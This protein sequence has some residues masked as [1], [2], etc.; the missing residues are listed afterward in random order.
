MKHIIF[1]LSDQQR[2]DTLGCYGQ[3]LDITPNLDRLAKQGTMFEYAF[4]PQ[5]VCGPTRAVLQSG[6]FA[7]RTS[8]YRNAIALPVEEANLSR[9]LKEAGYYTGYIGKW[10][11]A[12]N[13][14]KSDIDIGP[15]F[16]YATKPIPRHL[17]GGYDFFL[18]ADVLEYTSKGRGGGHIYDQDGKTISW[19]TEYRS[20][21]MNKQ[22][23][24]FIESHKDD[25]Q[26][27]FLFVSQI[28]PHHQNNENRFEGPEGSYDK[29]KERFVIPD[30][31]RSFE[32]D[33]IE[34]YPDYLGAIERLD[35]N[36]G[37]LIHTLEQHNLLED[38]LFIYTSDH[39]SHFRTRNNEY[40]RSCHDGSIRIP[41][42][43]HGPGFMGGN[44]IQELVSL[45]DIPATI[46]A[47]ANAT[48]PNDFD[49]APIQET[50]SN[51]TSWKQDIFV[52][53]SED[54]L[55][56]A[57]RTKRFKYSVK[58][59]GYEPWKG[60]CHA[61]S[62]DVYVD[63]YL[64]DLERDPNEHDNRIEDPAYIT[65]KEDLKKQLIKRMVDAGEQAPRILDSMKKTD[66]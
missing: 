30:D 2:F 8:C 53:I 59:P 57:I 37:E 48:I 5:P 29:F 61:M 33:Y 49:G 44:K 38:T 25:D 24:K 13:T 17:Q 40:K 58:A 22:A 26:P 1:Y 16:D 10:H 19:D 31:L 42:V 52:Q 65:I 50:L 20:D 55:S 35:Q 18:G 43:F 23:I 6:K 51:P 15:H 36:V 14:G 4:T 7:T 39:G 27:F 64:Y 62:S 12:T 21:F 46:L 11:L 54:S 63:E 32:G 41:M 9:Q 45:V 34:S 3:P 56:R 66:S 47:A 60:A 28:E